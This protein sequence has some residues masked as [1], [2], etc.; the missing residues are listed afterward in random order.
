MLL[1]DVR[2]ALLHRETYAAALKG[3]LSHGVA[4]DFA[5]R[6][7][8]T[9]EYLSNLL[10]PDHAPPSPRL[11]ARI[12]A[13]LSLDGDRK[14]ALLEHMLLAHEN[15]QRMIASITAQW[16]EG[17]IPLLL[18]ELAQAN[19]AA[20][21]ASGNDQSLWARMI[22]EM[23]GLLLRRFS[24][25]RHLTEYTHI[26]MIVQNMQSLLNRGEDALYTAKWIN[27][28]MARHDVD[29]LRR[30]SNA[31]YFV[32]NSL[33]AE[34]I[35]LR[36]LKLPKQAEQ[37]GLLIESML[38]SSHDPV[39]LYWLPHVLRAGAE[40]ITE[41]PRFTLSYAE[42]SID[43]GRRIVEARKDSDAADTLLLLDKALLNAYIAYG[44]ERSLKKGYALAQ[45]LEAQL[46]S[47]TFSPIRRAVVLASLASYYH[48]THEMDSFRQWLAE[49][50][51]LAAQAG[52]THQLHRARESY[53][54]QVDMIMTSSGCGG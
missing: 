50:V 11:A 23:G 8:I 5:R 28:V 6:I 13:A 1:E 36:N 52:L 4:E 9:P 37:L 12:V 20:N 40:S 27:T 24:P 19:D 3:M 15:R 47:G 51:Q 44:S 25:V 38:R 14:L 21:R 49:Y 53:G 43:R 48:R 46:A 35:A 39:V 54:A 41:L 29:K 16:R 34:V 42:A 22:V 17:M 2:V 30:E 31:A 7:G 18:G 32:I 26:A 45:R 10:D 33:Y